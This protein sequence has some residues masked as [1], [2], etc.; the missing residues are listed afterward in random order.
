MI[1]SNC[2]ENKLKKMF[3]TNYII[4]KFLKTIIISHL[5]LHLDF[6]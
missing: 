2:S 5:Y 6:Y 4:F 3:L 1:I